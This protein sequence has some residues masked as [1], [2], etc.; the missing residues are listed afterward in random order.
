MAKRIVSKFQDSPTDKELV[1]DSRAGN[2]HAYRQLVERHQE[3]LF[4]VAY[5]IM[6][7][8]EDAEDVVQEAFVKAFFSL[9][10]FKGESSIF[11]WLYRITF[12]MALDLKRKLK[13]RGGHHVEY[14]EQRNVSSDSGDD[15]PTSTPAEAM[16]SAI[17]SGKIESPFEALAR[18][19]TGERLDEVFSDLSEEHREIITLR[20]IDG[21]D[22]DEIADRLEIPRGTVMSRLFYARKTLQKALHDVAPPPSQKVG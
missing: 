21:L 12:N 20:E 16:E 2:R 14:K 6:K 5:D 10:K 18:K 22:Y 8:R 17:G 1:A 15:S 9:D 13:R 4:V 19:E 7:N 3:R 11:S